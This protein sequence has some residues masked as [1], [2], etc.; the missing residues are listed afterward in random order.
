MDVAPATA[1]DIVAAMAMGGSTLAASCCCCNSSSSSSSFSAA[2]SNPFRVVR[3]PSRDQTHALLPALKSNGLPLKLRYNFSVPLI[4]R[5]CVVSVYM[6]MCECFSFNIVDSNTSLWMWSIFSM[7]A[8]VFFPSTFTSDVLGGEGEADWGGKVGFLRR[9]F[10]AV[11]WSIDWQLGWWILTVNGRQTRLVAAALNGN[12]G[13]NEEDVSDA[14]RLL[15]QQKQLELAERIA[16]GEFTV[17]P[18]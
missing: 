14:E 8:N 13:D 10:V 17:L 18:R 7:L 5:K 1:M 12:A 16:S 2:S 11:G 9:N 15:L 6:F 3:F 4:Q